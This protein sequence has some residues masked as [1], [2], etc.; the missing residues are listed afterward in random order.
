M[1]PGE[2]IISSSSSTSTSTSTSTTTTSLKEIHARAFQSARIALDRASY[3]HHRNNDN[4]DVHNH[5]DD[6]SQSSLPLPFISPDADSAHVTG[7][8]KAGAMSRYNIQREGIV[9]SDED[10]SCNCRNC[11]CDCDYDY[12]S[13]ARDDEHKA[14]HS[15]SA[16]RYLTDFSS[17][18]Y[19][20]HGIVDYVLFAIERKLDLVSEQQQQ[21]SSTQNNQSNG[22]DKNDNDDVR[23]NNNNIN[24]QTMGW[25]QQHLGPTETSS[26]W[27]IKRFV[28]VEENNRE[29][30]SINNND[31][32][33]SSSSFLTEEGEHITLPMHTD[34]SLISIVIH[35]DSST[36]DGGGHGAL[37]LQYYHPRERKWIEPEAHGHS[38]ATIFVGSVL[39]HLTSGQFPAAK[40]RVIDKQQQQQQQQQQQ[41]EKPL[42]QQRM[43]ATLFVRPQP[44]ALLRVPLPSPWLIQQIQKEEDDRHVDSENSRSNDKTNQSKKKKPSSKP[45]ITFDAWLKRVA[46]NYEKQKNKKKKHIQNTTTT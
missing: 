23:N 19:S 43:A 7:F 28:E 44:S 30:E 9:F 46:K 33:S 29:E 4:E 40:H 11:D 18:F 45:P 16:C 17:M 21:R 14:N 20:L 13:R 32:K 10:C 6:E 22:D 41:E 34:P 2:H 38:V 25:F 1:K 8:H 42:K 12:D 39:A 3:Y 5:H 37:G 31:S 26:Q 15:C 36:I 35:D 27:H 24:N